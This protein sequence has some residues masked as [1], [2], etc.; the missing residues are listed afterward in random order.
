MNALIIMGKNN[1]THYYDD[2][3]KYHGSHYAPSSLVYICKENLGNRFA[4]EG[5]IGHELAVH[6]MKNGL[7]VVA[8]T[9]VFCVE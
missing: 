9:R 6:T 8:L 5:P 7:H 1:S 4:D 2:E 3:E